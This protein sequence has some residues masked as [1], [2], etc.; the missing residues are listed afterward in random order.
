MN[1]QNNLGAHFIASFIAVL[2]LR[3][4]CSIILV[5]CLV[6]CT[7]GQSDSIDHSSYPAHNHGTTEQVEQ[8]EQMEQ[9][10]QTSHSVH[11][12]PGGG[13]TQKMTPTHRSEMS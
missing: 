7:E 3:S 4:S 9:M 6:N 10:E 13:P 8:V 12:T 2:Q 1:N 11:S 5:A